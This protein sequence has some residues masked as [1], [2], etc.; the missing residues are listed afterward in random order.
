MFRNLNDRT[1]SQIYL[2]NRTIVKYHL[3]S[4]NNI[5]SETEDILEKNASKT[6][7]STLDKKSRGDKTNNDD[8]LLP[9]YVTNNN[10][11]EI[12][13]CSKNSEFL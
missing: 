11:N 4:D 2:R 9:R 10:S 1:I 12:H 7:Q 8:E 5:V 6:T 13:M 3:S